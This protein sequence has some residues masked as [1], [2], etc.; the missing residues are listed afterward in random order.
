MFA[1]RLN[2]GAFT[3]ADFDP[4]R[5][6]DPSALNHLGTS[7]LLDVPI[8]MFGKVGTT[9]D[10]MTAS[11]E[12]A[13]AG[14]RDATQELR[15]R[16]AEAYRQAEVAG[17]AVAVTEKVME[18]AKAREAEIELRVQAGGALLA[19]L[20]RARARRRQREADVAE[21][22]SEQRA[23]QAGLAR[24]LGAP[25]GVTYV[26]IDAPP[27]GRRA[28]RRRARWTARG[29]RQRPVLEA[30]RR[31]QEAASAFAK[32]EK[33]GLLPDIGAFV[34]VW[35]NR[36]TAGDGSQAWAAG[37]GV[38]W[39]PFDAGRGKRE[40][41][42]S[43]EARAAE[44]DVRAATDQVRLEVALA[45]RSATTAR[46][47]H[48]AASGGAEEGREALRV[49]QERRKAGLATLTDELETESAALGAALARDGCRGRGGP[50]RCGARARRRGDLTMTAR[51]FRATLT[52][53]AFAAA[54]CGRPGPPKSAVAPPGP[55]REVASRRG[56][57][58]GRLRPRRG[59]GRRSG[60]QARGP[61]GPRGRLGG[62]AS[63]PGGPIGQ[64][65]RGRGSPRRRGAPR[66][67]RGRGG[68]RAGG[69]SDLDR[70]RSLLEKGAATPR[71]LE[72]MTA[73]AGAA[74][75]QLMA[76]KDA[77][78]YSAL[79]APFDGRIAARHVNL[80]D[81]VTP[82]TVLIEIE[83]DGGLELKA[84][85]EPALGAALRPGSALKALVDGQP[86]P[87]AA[88]VTAIAPAGDP[89]THR[90][91]LKADLP[92]ASGL[93]AG[94]FARL[95]VPGPAAEAWLT[96]PA[97]A[98]FERGGSRA[99]SWRRT[100]RRACAGS[101]PARATGD[102][103]EVRAGLEAGE[104]VV[105][106]PA[107]LA[108]G[109]PIASRRS[110]RRSSA[111]PVG[112]AGQIA[113]AFL[114]S[115]LTPLVIAASLG[116]GA[117]AL[118]AT[119]REEEPQIRVPMVD[120][121]VAWPGAEPAEV[122][123]R[124]V[125]PIERILWGVTGVEHI[126]SVSRPGLALVTVRFKVNE[127]NEDSL[128]KLHERQ[129][130]MGWMLPPG[131]LPPIVELHSI[132]DVPVP[133]PH[134]VGRAAGRATAC[135]R[136]R[137]SSRRSCRR[138]PR[139][140][141][142]S[143]SAASP[144]WCASSP[145]PT[146]WPRPASAG[147]S[148]RAR[149]RP[150]RSARAPGPR[151]ATTARS[152]SRSGRCSASSDEVGRVVVGV[153]H[154]RP[155]YVSSVA[156][157]IDGPDEAQDA[158]LLLAGPAGAAARGARRRGASTPAVT[159]AIAKRPGANATALAERRARE[160][161]GAAAAAAARRRPASTSRATTAR[162]RRRSRTSSSSTCCSRRCRSSP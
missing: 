104:H 40:A 26:P 153:T 87:L 135:G 137:P 155:V 111:V 25:E 15:F 130:A 110:A 55:A 118:L 107:G 162:P 31:R 157:V 54:A 73:A 63:L 80:G 113:R 105:L 3:A 121:L 16:V 39:T 49:V 85:V 91:E 60:P 66:V 94:L 5:L 95:L 59:A 134:A 115:K 99:S 114:D 46:E 117:L 36:I 161:R 7:A 141:A 160:G 150:P 116:L 146:A 125:E 149:S 53:A 101:P 33:N 68:G 57:S 106:R 119:P 124:I 58:H 18:V 43:A 98:V 12:A 34:Q 64:G 127:S 44:Q 133:D 102:T 129:S 45:Y 156:R 75:A 154:G 14:L 72:Q 151:C 9:A 79:R 23:A 126:Y 82:G 35:D 140:A 38:R 1:N 128:V 74:Q 20:L 78:S 132:D 144:A 28:R 148:S 90:F 19:D 4:A 147:R 88:T 84:T 143:S 112:F 11:G 100:A 37:L 83:G 109:D 159:I 8:D 67:R 89:T 6:N 93:R 48:A 131:A 62:R 152:A 96:V 97:S 17:R 71:E 47:R 69:R 120:V 30:A 51:C 108:D 13:A 27:A 142:S 139:R 61:R 122:E 103:V 52:L 76:A 22:S 56:D 65:R 41:A 138:C 158:V 145:T 50:G 21:R 24:L 29:L 77:L 10:A 136:S 70:T 42:A 2:S 86:A 123:S 92:A 32:S 81:V